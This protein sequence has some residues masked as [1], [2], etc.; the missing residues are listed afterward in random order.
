VTGAVSNAGTIMSVNPSTPS[1]GNATDG[2][3]IL[4]SSVSAGLTNSGVI[5]AQSNDPALS[6]NARL[7]ATG[8]F[9]NPIINFNGLMN[10]GSI[11]VT[12]IE[13][14]TAMAGAQSLSLVYGLSIYV[15]N[16]G[17]LR[18]TGGITNAGLITASLASTINVNS[19]AGGSYTRASAE[20]TGVK[21]QVTGGHANL[22]AGNFSG[23]ITN[24]GAIL[25][26][27]T[28]AATVNGAASSAIVDL[29]GL[30]MKVFGGAVTTQSATAGGIFS[31]T[32][33]NSGTIL[34]SLTESGSRMSL[35]SDF[36]SGIKIAS[37]G[38]NKYG[39]LTAGA[40]FTG[41]VINSGT[42]VAR[43]AIASAEV[44]SGVS[45][46]HLS[47]EGG[48]NA[49]GGTIE[50]GVTN[51]G[52]VMAAITSMP[53]ASMIA[54]YQ[55]PMVKATGLYAYVH[56]GSAFNGGMAGGG[57]FQN[58]SLVNSGTI[59]AS[60]RT[61]S[62]VGAVAYGVKV[63]VT[64]GMATGMAVGLGGNFTGGITNSGT[65]LASLTGTGSGF[66]TAA[67]LAISVLP[68]S[69]ALATA[70]TF[71][72]AIVNS[73]T[74]AATA[75][76]VAYGISIQA[77]GSRTNAGGIISGN[78]VNTGL[79]SAS[80][81]VIADGISINVTNFDEPGV[82]PGT[83]IGD[84]TN[85]GTIIGAIRAIDLEF[86][87]SATV[88]HQEGGLLSGSLVGAG[89]AAGQALL[90]SGG[91]IQLSPFQ[92]ITGFSNFT[93]TGGTLLLEVRPLVAPSI[94]DNTIALHG[95]L[96][97]VPFAGDVPFASDTTYRDVIIANHPIDFAGETVTTSSPIFTANLGVDPLNPNALDLHLDLTPAARTLDLTQNLRFAL[98]ASNVLRDS[99][100]HRLLEG[101]VYDGGGI[102][103][104][105]LSGPGHQIAGGPG[106]SNEGA[107][108]ARGYGV[109]GSADAS[110]GSSSF[111]TRR[112]G[113]V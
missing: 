45:G 29:Y 110:D 64:G 1:N 88:I 107:L 93:Q 19:G 80:A 36:L 112:V 60:A 86:D 22:T 56:G 65:I 39:I 54:F 15:G 18:F 75:S 78:I 55:Q 46:I 57:S 76:F 41:P 72:G 13:G 3:V 63:R 51:S 98:D 48:F 106:E 77:H 35:T 42:I 111:D 99:I 85:T 2:V 12:S 30:S 104:A 108:W 40:T 5:L 38:G 66:Q 31:G 113:F 101:V 52:L 23:G 109:L 68:G 96:R 16:D 37:Y 14:V 34:A 105:S 33:T 9:L 95:T 67:G 47:A 94:A 92:Q 27:G 81:G 90:L 50:G 62:Y 84:I 25:V 58:G 24:S 79:I 69:G 17:L 32:V 11:G 100:G 74:L 59:V 4:S 26:S 73:G 28:I 89:K 21:V 53:P 43:S 44:S 61:A 82:I 70:G 6:G 87:P 7:L 49:A 91:T 83:F 71:T 10:S 20:V 8:I 97:I 103:S 102:K